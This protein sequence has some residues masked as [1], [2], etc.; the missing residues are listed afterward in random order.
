L[1]IDLVQARGRLVPVLLDP[2]S[3]SSLVRLPQFSSM[4]EAG[5]E[6]GIYRVRKGVVRAAAP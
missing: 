4:L 2:R 5:K 3:T 6:F 1:L